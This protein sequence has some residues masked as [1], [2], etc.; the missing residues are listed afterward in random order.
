MTRRRS[1]RVPPRAEALRPRMHARKA[2]HP[3]GGDRR[4][5]ASWRF[6]A[7]VPGHQKRMLRW[8]RAHHLVVMPTS[9]L[10]AQRTPTRSTP[11]PTTPHAWWG[12]DMTTGMVAGVGW[13]SIVVVLDGA[14]QT[15][16]GDSAG[17]PC[18]A[19]P[20]LAALAR[21]VNRQFPAGARGQGLSLRSDHGSQPT[22]M[23]CMAACGTLGL[24]QACTS[25]STP[26]GHADTERVIRTRQEEGLWW[27]EWTSPWELISALGAWIE[28]DHEHSLHSALGDK[29]PG[30]CAREDHTSHR[31]P[32]VAA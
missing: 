24:H 25:D 3:F 8:L 23:A 4:L 28:S 7:P 16:V 6:V 29:T 9:Q 32:F 31:P 1:L 30:P 18:P 15:I 27:P 13:L 10:T 26:K 21:A 20:W 17:R 14:T 22:A 12:I 11:R 5:W 2:E 19:R